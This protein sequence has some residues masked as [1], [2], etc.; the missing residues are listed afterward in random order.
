[1]AAEEEVTTVVEEAETVTET[2]ETVMMMVTNK[3]APTEE[4]LT[5]G[6]EAIGTMIGTDV[7]APLDRVIIAPDTTMTKGTP[8]VEVAEEVVEEEPREEAVC[9]MVSKPSSL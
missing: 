5:V 2:I 6:T 3:L 8:E 1:M 4:D 9:L 7:I